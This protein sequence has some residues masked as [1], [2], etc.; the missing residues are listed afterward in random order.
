MTF[1]MFRQ[2]VSGQAEWYHLEHFT[3][4]VSFR[5]PMILSEGREDLSAVFT[6]ARS[7]SPGAKIM[8]SIKR[9]MSSAK[10]EM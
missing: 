1:G 5:D 4:D 9:I 6:L 2:C 7:V 10:D 3:Q 8:T